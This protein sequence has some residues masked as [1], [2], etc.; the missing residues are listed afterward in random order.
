MFL[1]CPIAFSLIISNKSLKSGDIFP[2]CSSP[3]QQPFWGGKEKN[4]EREREEMMGD[5]KGKASGWEPKAFF[6]RKK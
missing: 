6:L 2:L 1:C 5:T 3:E 4:P